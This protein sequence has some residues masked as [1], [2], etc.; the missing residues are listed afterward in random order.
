MN[1]LSHN[2]THIVHSW[3]FLAFYHIF[4][5]NREL[6]H[7]SSVQLSALGQVYAYFR[8]AIRTALRWGVKEGRWINILPYE[9][10]L[11]KLLVIFIFL[12]TF[13]A[14]PQNAYTMHLKAQK[15]NNTV[16]QFSLYCEWQ[17][18]SFTFLVVWS[19]KKRWSTSENRYSSSSHMKVMVVITPSTR[20][21]CYY[22]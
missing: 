13:S 15:K 6:Q 20:S 10:M 18:N 3:F 8:A 19:L 21:I 7:H 11:L 2:G 12:F 14:R 5:A 9:F 16:T 22:F 17:N 4:S 1:V